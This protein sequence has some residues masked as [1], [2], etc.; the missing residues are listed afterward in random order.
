VA[1]SNSIEKLINYAPEK[2]GEFHSYHYEWID[3]LHFLLNPKA[4]LGDRAKSYIEAAKVVF[5]EM[6]WEGDG[7]IQLLWLPPFVFPTSSEVSPEGVI[8]WHV[9]QMEDGIS[10]LLSPVALPFKQ[11]A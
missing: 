11:L 1:Y 7:D 2:I 6:D 9:K 5:R 10:F 3:N 4:V 8:I